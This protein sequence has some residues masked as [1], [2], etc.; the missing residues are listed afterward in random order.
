[1]LCAVACWATMMV[2]VRALSTEYTSFQIL[3]I[4]TAVGLAMLTPLFVRNG[5]KAVRTRRLGLH[6]LRGS[7]AYGGQITLF[8][9]I[10]MI[11]L[12]DVVALTF[13]QPIFI[14]LMACAALG[15]KMTRVRALATAGGFLGV[16]VI[17]R[18]GFAEVGV[19]T[20][21][22][23]VSS[24][25]YAGSNVCIKLLMRTE[26]S[27]VS[28]VWAN[29]VMCPL[30][31]VPA[32]FLWVTPTP[33][34]LALMVG[35]GVSGTTG[36]WCVARAYSAADMS[37]VVPFDFLRLPLVAVAAWLLFDEPTGLW[38]WAGAAV[39]FVSTWTLGRA[40]ARGGRRASRR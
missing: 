38:T 5:T 25:I 31:A 14:V 18:P 16:L 33:A 39:I 4:R 34:D 13:T 21:I 20:A 9:G 29:L 40:E 19:G 3:F 8:V 32:A 27:S 17:V 12:S 6:V 7:L 11:A 26:A 35:V 23:I 24:L 15:E 1:M 28:V 10:A 2:L 36:I 30:A 37:T 22:V